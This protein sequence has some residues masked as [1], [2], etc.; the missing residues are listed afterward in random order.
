LDDAI[1]SKI[2]NSFVPNGLATVISTVDEF[3]QYHQKIEQEVYPFAAQGQSA[4]GF[5]ARL[6]ELIAQIR[7]AER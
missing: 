7:I 3:L 4:S 1:R 6:Q 5:M 2:K